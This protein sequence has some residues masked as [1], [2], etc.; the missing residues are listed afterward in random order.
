MPAY[1]VR[2]DELAIT[3]KKKKTS[4]VQM[5]ICTKISCV[6]KKEEISESYIE[7]RDQNSKLSSSDWYVNALI[8]IQKLVLNTCL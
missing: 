5:V 7:S 4:L 6:R 3:E 2:Q 1:E 8:N